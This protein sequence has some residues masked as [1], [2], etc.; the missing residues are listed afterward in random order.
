MKVQI[1]LGN[2]YSKQI[3]DLILIKIR[4]W[5][6]F[7]NAGQLCAGLKLYLEVDR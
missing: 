7:C 4:T 3:M 2:L 1:H 6:D 5:I